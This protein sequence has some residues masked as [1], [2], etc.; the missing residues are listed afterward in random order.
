MI[1]LK[2]FEFFRVVELSKLKKNYQQILK[3]YPLKSIL[4][5]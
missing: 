2:D 1:D 3:N 4:Y 5:Q